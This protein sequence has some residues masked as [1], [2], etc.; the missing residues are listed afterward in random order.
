M[1]DFKTRLDYND[2]LRDVPDFPKPG[3][4]FKDITPLLSAPA[5]FGA[6]IADLCDLAAQ[7]QPTHIAGIESRGFL[8]GAPMAQQMGIS[9]IPVRKPGKLPWDTYSCEYELEYGKNTLELH[10]D[11]S[12]AGDRVLLIDDLLATGGSADAAIQLLRKTGAEI[13]QPDDD[14]AGHQRFSTR[15]SSSKTA[16]AGS[17]DSASFRPTIPM[18]LPS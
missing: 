13:V 11:A 15:G 1:S 3:I 6:S 2:F 4:L 16:Q 18:I 14:L 10:T 7:Y 5:A 9:F 17:P 8:F 12:A